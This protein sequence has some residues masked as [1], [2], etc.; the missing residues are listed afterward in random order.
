[1]TKMIL[2]IISIGSMLAVAVLGVF[3]WR[4]YSHELS[5][6]SSYTTQNIT[7]GNTA[8][9]VFLADTEEKRTRG[10]M[11]ITDLPKDSGMLFLFTDTALRTFWNKNTLIDLD[12]VWI[13]GG[14]IV[15]ISQLPSIT[16]SGSVVLVSSP[17]PVDRVLEVLAGWS[18]RNGVQVGDSIADIPK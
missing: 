3:L 8:M 14:K 18:V 17:E 15:G 5:P 10:L 12:I 1:M 2:I 13:A 7:V 9:R 16:R 6:L 11:H 4:R